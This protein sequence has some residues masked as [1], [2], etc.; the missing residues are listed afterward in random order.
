MFSAGLVLGC[1]LLQ[2]NDHAEDIRHAFHAT[3]KILGRFGRNSQQ[4]KQYHGILSNF[5]DA[6]ANYQRKSRM[7]RLRL[8]NSNVER[9]LAFD[10]P[11]D[12]QP[13]AFQTQTNMSPSRVA[14]V[15][16]I[17]DDS[18]GTFESDDH[19]LQWNWPVASENNEILRMFLDPCLEHLM[20]LPPPDF[21]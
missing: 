15:T 7:K 16:I 20:N 1:S 12:Q 6:I 8:E 14:S 9:I 13:V 11:N 21:T 18:I 4:A 19:L 2:L 17:N 3:S 10:E 5:A